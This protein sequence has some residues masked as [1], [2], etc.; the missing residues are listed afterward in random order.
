MAC[1]F[2]KVFTI[3]CS[4][5]TIIGRAKRAPHWGV[6]SRFRVIYMYVGMYVYVC[7]WEKLCMLKC[8]GG[9]TWSKHAQAQSQFWEFE[10]KCHLESLI[11]PSSFQLNRHVTAVLFISTI[12][13]QL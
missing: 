6:Q 10:T 13:E 11:L 9:I 8:V 12:L 5:S 2:F 4:F 7:L 3:V 1:Y